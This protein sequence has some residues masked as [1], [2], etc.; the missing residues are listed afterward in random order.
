MILLEICKTGFNGSYSR[1]TTAAAW[2]QFGKRDHELGFPRI[3]EQRGRGTNSQIVRH[4]D[5]MI[6]LRESV[7]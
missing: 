7:D 3:S 5:C 6:Q 1:D 4:I 2:Q